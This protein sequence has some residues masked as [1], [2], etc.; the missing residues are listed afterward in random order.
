MYS[1]ILSRNEEIHENKKWG[2]RRG[3]IA[4]ALYRSR[5]RTASAR[6]EGSVD[7]YCQHRSQRTRSSHRRVGML[8]VGMLHCFV[9]QG[10]AYG[11]PR[12]ER[13]TPSLS[14]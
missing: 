4:I 6:N 9:L 3:Q 12:T 1:Q 10:V 14:Q 11:R 8:Q 7:Y 5:S 13:E 2:G